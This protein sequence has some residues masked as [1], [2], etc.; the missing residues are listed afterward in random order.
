M[1]FDGVEIVDVSRRINFDSTT[2]FP[3]IPQA[4]LFLLENIRLTQ[5]EGMVRAGHP[6]RGG[7]QK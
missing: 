1:T 3:V 7:L 5:A 4:S 6:I 2:Y